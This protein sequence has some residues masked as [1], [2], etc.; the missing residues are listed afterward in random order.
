MCCVST[1]SKLDGPCTLRRCDNDGAASL[2]RVLSLSVSRRAKA[3]AESRSPLA[4]APRAATPQHSSLGADC[5]MGD[6][7]MDTFRGTAN[8]TLLR[9]GLYSKNNG[10]VEVNRNGL[11]RTESPISNSLL[12]SVASTTQ[13]VRDP[14]SGTLLLYRSGCAEVTAPSSKQPMLHSRSFH[15]KKDIDVTIQQLRSTT[16][17]SRKTNEKVGTAGT[18]TG[19]DKS[20]SA[21]TKG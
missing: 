14:I 21:F 11:V 19:L 13:A 16:G 6:A 2:T 15:L 5:R 9:T 12:V 1:P 3:C 7:G 8:S 20:L 10:I 18:P 17:F 4:S